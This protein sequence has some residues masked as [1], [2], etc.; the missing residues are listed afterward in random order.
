[1]TGSIEKESGVAKEKG[2]SQP[3]SPGAEKAPMAFIT[4]CS[5]CGIT[6][7]NKLPE[8]FYCVHAQCPMGLFATPF[9]RPIC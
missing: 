2:L 6:F 9:N 1:M 5:Y 7:G 4:Y 3:S 8:G